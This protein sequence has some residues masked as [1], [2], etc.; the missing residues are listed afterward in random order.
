MVLTRRGSKSIARWLPDEILS[1]TM[2]YASPMTL[3]AL[4]STSRL[5]R[6]LA[7]PLLYRTVYLRNQH[8]IRK[9]TT[10][11]AKR[12]T[13]N[14]PYSRH[15]RE[16]TIS[17]G[18]FMLPVEVVDGALSMLPTLKN[19]WSL[20]ILWFNKVPEL[21]SLRHSPFPKLSTFKYR[22]YNCM[23][24]DGK[25]HN[26]IAFIT[27][28]INHHPTITFLS[29]TRSK[30]MF[31]LGPPM[32][33]LYLPNLMGYSGPASFVPWLVCPPNS[34]Y[35]MSLYWYYD[36][37]DVATP[38]TAMVSSEIST[39]FCHSDELSE[40][41]ILEQVA[42]IKPRIQRLI[43]NKI[44]GIRD[45]ISME[46]AR[47]IAKPLKSLENLVALEFNGA[48]SGAGPTP[49][50]RWLDSVICVLWSEHCNTLLR[51]RIHGKTWERRSHA[52]RFKLKRP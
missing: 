15:V 31:R 17:V 48:P 37:V 20:A 18:L 22:V 4:C 50:D 6:A 30:L 35:V 12:E 43:F 44:E 11:L 21:L 51:I 42:K 23:F 32:E 49:Q 45:P 14:D 41:A 27:P 8:T 40:C 10:T 39:L 36:D 9:F 47:E 29:L 26:S 7:T 3:V 24:P 1:E 52:S 34:I 28:F 16:F 2:G 5:M 19:V 13:S 46:Y 25:F 33:P 38:L